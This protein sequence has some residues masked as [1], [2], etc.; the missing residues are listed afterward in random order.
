VAV[1]RDGEIAGHESEDMDRGQAEALV[2]MIRRVMVAAGLA[3]DDLDRLAVTIGPG[4]FTGLRIGLATA[5]GLALAAACPLIGV[6]T[7]E[8]VAFAV[9]AAELNGVEILAAIETKRV[10]LYVQRFRDRLS[11]IST[12]AAVAPDDLADWVGDRPQLVVGDGGN[13]AL[14]ALSASGAIAF[15]SLA[16]DQPDARTIAAI[17]ASRPAAAADSHPR[18]LYLGAPK[19]TL[20]AAGANGRSR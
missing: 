2:P 10:D 11:P 9:P 3:F 18:P 7:L 8:A 14:A 6:T 16:P 17:A 20:P 13:R 15:R 5:R 19:V 4:T 12:P 1:W